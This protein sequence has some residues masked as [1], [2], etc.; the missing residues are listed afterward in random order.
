MPDPY[1]L[2]DGAFYKA[3]LEVLKSEI[4][5]GEAFEQAIQ[6]AITDIALPLTVKGDLVTHSGV[7]DVSLSVGPDGKFLIADSAAV[8]GLK[9]GTL[10]DVS[11]LTTGGLTFGLSTGGLGQDPTVLFWDIAAKALGIGT[12]VPDVNAI[13]DLATTTKGFLQPR[14]A[15]FDRDLMASPLTGLSIYNPTTNQPEHFDGTNWVA[16]AGPSTFLALPDTPGSF[17][18][19][20]LLKANGAAT[21]I[22]YSTLLFDNG[23][24][25]GIATATPNSTLEVNGSIRVTRAQGAN[26]LIITPEPSGEPVYK[27]NLGGTFSFG[28]RSN[29]A[30]Q[31]GTAGLRTDLAFV[32]IDDTNGIHR[33]NFKIFFSDAGGQLLIQSGHTAFQAGRAAFNFDTSE[34]ISTSDV[35]RLKNFGS[36]LLTVDASGV[37]HSTTGGF[38]FPDATIQTTAA[39]TGTGD[40]LQNGNSFGTIMTV[41]TNDV[42][43]FSLET[44]GIPRLDITSTGE[45][46]IGKQVGIGVTTILDIKR[47]HN[48][49]S[50]IRIENLD[51]GTSVFAGHS[52]ATVTG[53]ALIG[54]TGNGTVGVAGPDTFLIQADSGTSG[55]IIYAA[56]APGKHQWRTGTTISMELSSL[57]DLQI[58]SL[59]TS[60]AGFVGIR[61]D[62]NGAVNVVFENGITTGASGFISSIW[63]TDAGIFSISLARAGAAPGVAF[64]ADAVSINADVTLTQGMIFLT[65]GAP[66]R[67]VTN[68][69]VSTGEVMRLLSGSNTLQFKGGGTL[70]GGA[71]A[72]TLTLSGGAGAASSISIGA[73]DE[74]LALYGGTPVVQHSTTGQLSGFL[75]GT[76]TA[77]RD[78]STWTGG[79]GA[80]AYTT[81]DVVRALK[82]IGAMAA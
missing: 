77:S 56:R 54:M 53:S 64:A 67:W 32:E 27:V 66:F 78:D 69:N 62:F 30:V 74:L 25:F 52:F 9:Y 80:A 63:K 20:R 4:T 58:G 71:G 14:V 73:S 29:G 26:D 34:T 59:A 38:K 50:I 13:L 55:G 22:E 45:V 61:K 51:V 39:V 40:I 18:A 10:A 72:D 44:S 82:N 11:G 76:G 21:A 35:L 37:V 46:L 68:G 28:V 12:N 65:D 17:T 1:Y 6:D 5:G 43:A 24:F 33:G 23:S 79:I 60:T 41:G 42:F 15:T 57:G 47:D 70:Q 75:A 48:T 16:T 2:A 81:G 31:L 19:N 49:S 7:K 3:V 8:F 36:T